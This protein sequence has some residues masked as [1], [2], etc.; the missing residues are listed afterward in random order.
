MK[1]LEA[2]AAATAAMENILDQVLAVARD[3]G[4]KDTDPLPPELRKLTSFPNASSI[5][6][7]SAISWLNKQVAYLEILADELAIVDNTRLVRH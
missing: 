3:Q 4:L 5:D 2:L 7:Y 6:T 1:K